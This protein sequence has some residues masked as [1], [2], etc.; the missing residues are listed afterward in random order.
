MNEKSIEFIKES[1]LRD[2][3]RILKENEQEKLTRNVQAN[4]Y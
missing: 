3:E 4:K 1:I 2:N